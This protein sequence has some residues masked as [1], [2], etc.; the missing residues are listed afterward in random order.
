MVQMTFMVTFRRE[1]GI[2]GILSPAKFV[3]IP[4]NSNKNYQKLIYSMALR[5]KSLNKL[6]L[7][8]NSIE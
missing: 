8:G 1:G 5:L 2:G 3:C 7:C 6:Y 4:W